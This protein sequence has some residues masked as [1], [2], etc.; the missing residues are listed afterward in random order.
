M[1]S[2]RAMR[3]AMWPTA[4]D[5][6]ELERSVGLGAR[7]RGSDSGGGDAQRLRPG[8]ARRRRGDKAAGAAAGSSG[9]L[10]KVAGECAAARNRRLRRRQLAARVHGAAAVGL[11]CEE[12]EAVAAASRGSER[13]VAGGGLEQREGVAGRV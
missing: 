3:E 4:L 11:V 8:S 2:E 7:A 10:G 12:R 5:L 13:G 9:E 1:V 6:V